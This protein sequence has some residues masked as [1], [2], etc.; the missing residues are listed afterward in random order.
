MTETPRTLA[1]EWARYLAIQP[2]GAPRVQLIVTENAF[3]AGATAMFSLIAGIHDPKSKEIT[4]AD[5]AAM[6]A[7]FKELIDFR[8]RIAA[9]AG[10]API[11]PA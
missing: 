9:R 11:T 7:L 3:H 10:R 2:A 5:L 6:D 8:N 1:T 4:P